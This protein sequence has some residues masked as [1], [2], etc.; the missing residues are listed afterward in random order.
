MLSV[1]YISFLCCDNLFEVKKRR[2]IEIGTEFLCLIAFIILQQ[3]IR[4]DLEEP[5]KDVLSYMFIAVMA[6]I[7]V[8]NITYMILV[9]IE[10]RKDKKRAQARMKRL[11]YMVKTS[12][13]Q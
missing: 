9:I 11:H 10:S 8:C 2:L 4:I 3:F 6:L 13:N 7:F 12:L 1:F 5:A